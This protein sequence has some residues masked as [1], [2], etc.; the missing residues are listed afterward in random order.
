MKQLIYCLIYPLELLTQIELYRSEEFTLIN[1]RE[2]R[3]RE[4]GKVNESIDS[5]YARTLSP[6]IQLRKVGTLG[7]LQIGQSRN[8]SSPICIYTSGN[9]LHVIIMYSAKISRRIIFALFAE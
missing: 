6:P 5:P 4:G 3:R 2:R 9:L 7:S 1:Y 8:T